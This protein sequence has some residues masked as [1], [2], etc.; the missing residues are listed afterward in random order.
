MIAVKKTL[1]IFCAAAALFII[2][3]GVAA[4]MEEGVF[5]SI[6]PYD[7]PEKLTFAASDNGYTSWQRS[8]I[9]GLTD[10][11]NMGAQ[12]TYAKSS[13]AN[14]FDTYIDDEG[15][16]VI[17][18]T[19]VGTATLN[20][21][22]TNNYTLSETIKVE[23]G[24]FQDVLDNSMW[25]GPGTYESLGD[26][27]WGEE[28]ITSDR[29]DAA[30]GDTIFIVC[31]PHIAGA[32]A[33]LTVGGIDVG[34]DTEYTEEGDEDFRM[35]QYNFLKKLKTKIVLTIKWAG[36]SRTY[37]GTIRSYSK[38]K[39]KKIKKNSK[40]G[41]A[42]LYDVHKGDYL[43]VKVGKK[44]V[45]TIKYRK[46]QYLWK[47]T[48]KWSNKKRMKKGTVVRYYLYNKYKQKLATAKKVVGK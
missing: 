37:Y 16:V 38:I 1:K 44:F 17:Y 48:S 26:E 21:K 34:P 29:A 47:I 4:L 8:L 11:P 23:P 33:S 2:V 6:K 14:V 13:N 10:G 46:Y 18:P 25:V 5:A 30:Y 39:P 24:Y 15:Y 9:W 22:D 3:S 19:G 43:K 41:T 32:T 27:D 45:K 31:Y 36:A 35:F 20:I 28:F 12:I 7:H 42:V 40:S